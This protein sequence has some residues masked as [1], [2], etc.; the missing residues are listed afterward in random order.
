MNPI[1]K[2]VIWGGKRLKEVFGKE[3]PSCN[4][5][6]S[7]EIACHENGTSLVANG[8]LKGKSL[9][10]VIYIY[11][12]NALGTK[13]WEEGNNKFP[14]LVKFIDASD[15]LSVQV[16]PEDEYA[17]IHEGDFGKTEMWIVLDAKPD[18][19]LVYGVKPKV[20]KKELEKGIKE[21][22]LEKLL[23]FVDVKKGDV[24]FIPAGTIHAIGAGILI[25]EIQQNSDTTYRVYDWNRVDDKGNS[26]E[27]HVKKAL[28][29]SVL[30]DVVGKEKL[31]GRIVKEGKNIRNYLVSCKYFSTEIIE[32]NT[33]SK[34]SLNGE[35]FNLLIFIEGEGRITYKG[36]YVPFK[37]G[38]SFFIPAKMGDYSIV[39]QS[40]LIK[41]YI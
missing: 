16:H 5:G 31:K 17:R 18:A 10:E 3:I 9:K 30:S 22:T 26:R 20:T 19:K 35:K 34:E 38:D 12:K 36:G 27:L 29:V 25:A 24:F 1:Y 32:I 40:K 8:E 28:D 2:E 39:G 37:K 6:E 33:E 11:G 23:N 41:T 14:L 13:I 7:W 21:G 15:K 4:T